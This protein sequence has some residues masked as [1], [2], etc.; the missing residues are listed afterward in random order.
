VAGIGDVAN[1]L[2]RAGSV[3]LL[4]EGSLAVLGKIKVMG[5]FKGCV[6]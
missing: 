4:I 6:C 5:E 1:H 2:C 3:Y